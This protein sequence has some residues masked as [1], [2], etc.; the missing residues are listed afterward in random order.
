MKRSGMRNLFVSSRKDSSLLRRLEWHTGF[1]DRHL[2]HFDRRGRNDKTE[3]VVSLCG[4]ANNLRIVQIQRKQKSASA[5]LLKQCWGTEEKRRN[6][7]A[8]VL[9][10]IPVS[11]CLMN[12]SAYCGDWS[13][14]IVF[15][16]FSASL[17]FGSS[18]KNSLKQ[19]NAFWTSF[20]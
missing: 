19:Y 20:L 8:P 6:S 18:L 16:V 12:K 13:S 10:F 7:H 17:F 9:C 4:I 2:F 11:L 5:M 3:L 1:L 15:L 14:S